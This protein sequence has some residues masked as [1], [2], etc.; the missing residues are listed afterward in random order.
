LECRRGGGG[1]VAIQKDIIDEITRL[2]VDCHEL[3]RSLL[4]GE[5]TELTALYR[6]LFR[7]RTTEKM[8]DLM[9][10]VGQQGA[11]RKLGGQPAPSPRLMPLTGGKPAP[12][13]AAAGGPRV[14]TTP[15]AAGA[16]G[17]RGSRPVAVRPNALPAAARPGAPGAHEA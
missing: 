8:K 10:R 13:P 6:I 15:V 11:A 17:R 9:Q 4:D 3:H 5:F 12:F 2:G 14:L 7:I 16:A 1:E